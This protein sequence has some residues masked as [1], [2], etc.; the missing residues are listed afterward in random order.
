MMA[1]FAKIDENN[2]V[3]EVL[4]VDNKDLLNADNVEEEELG[5]QF[6]EN[7]LGHSK[8]KK[9]SYNT[10]RGKHYTEAEDGTSSE[11]PDQAK[12]FRKNHAG[13]GYTYDEG[14]DAFIPPKTYASWTLNEDTCWWE[15]PIAYPDDGKL[16]EWNEA[17]T[18]WIEVEE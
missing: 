10:R 3:L 12:S 14:R 1:S 16:Y 4:V 17:T 9:T 13:K 5:R 2:V 8:W 6:L 15:A 7:L 18:N 11:S